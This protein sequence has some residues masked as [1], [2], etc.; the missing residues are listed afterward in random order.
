MIRLFQN[1]VVTFSLYLITCIILSFCI[2]SCKTNNPV[3]Q[4]TDLPLI[5]NKSI[6]FKETDTFA[7]VGRENYEFAS[8]KDA[9][10]GIGSR[11]TIVIMDAVHTES[12]IIIDKNI[13]ILG[14]GPEETIIRGAEFASEAPNRIIEIMEES[15]VFLYN[16]TISNGRPSEMLRRGGG[17]LSFG[18]LEI[19]NCTIRDNEAVYGAGIFTN[20]K[21]V[22]RDSTIS[23]NR[24]YRAPSAEMITGLGCTGSGGGL[25]TEKGAD[26]ELYRCLVN[27]NTSLKKGGGIFAACETSVY[28][29]NCTITG[30]SSSRNGGGIHNRGDFYLLHCTIADNKSV[31]K[32]GGIFNY[33]HLDIVATLIANNMRDDFSEGD[34]GRGIYGKGIIGL[35]KY[36]FVSDGSLPGTL[37]GDPGLKKL[38]DNGVV[39]PDIL[40]SLRTKTDK[41]RLPFSDQR[42]VLRDGYF[43]IGAFEH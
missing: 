29:E 21:L 11:K 2:F 18:N 5:P 33:G 28:L 19:V 15:N 40:L 24:T 30:N 9:L 38:M 22:I 23:G 1:R 34:D 36:N 32:G 43:D 20:S 42:G 4:N 25:K 17:I 16:L 14:Y 41:F 26:V 13:S 39:S 12:G 6:I 8:I 7:L 27:G 35:N 10:A 37:S 3:S 31:K